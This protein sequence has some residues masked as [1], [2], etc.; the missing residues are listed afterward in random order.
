MRL[1]LAGVVVAIVLGLTGC[2][3]FAID[4]GSLDYQKAKSFPPLQLP[5]GQTTRSIS[6]IYPVPEVLAYS[7]QSPSFH[8]QNGKRY[9]LPEPRPLDTSNL[10]TTVSVGKPTAP[11]M[12]KDGNGTP[13]LRVE[14]NDDQIWQMVNQAIDATGL[15]VVYR[16]QGLARVDLRINNKPVMLRFNRTGILTT[17]TAQ[18]D[19][20]AL[21]DQAAA[22]DLFNQIITRWPS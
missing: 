18:D 11:V 19:K 13:I 7:D 12:V 21:I 20:N 16:N 9:Q 1:G 14:G 2:S 5:A 10:A 15:N 4:N 8:N 6:P 17:I 22:T 3:R